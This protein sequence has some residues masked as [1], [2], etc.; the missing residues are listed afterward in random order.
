VTLEDVGE[1]AHLHRLDEGTVVA[2][3][4]AQAVVALARIDN[5][6][7]RPARVINR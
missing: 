3:W 4:H 5:G 2:A 7:L 6:S 1:R